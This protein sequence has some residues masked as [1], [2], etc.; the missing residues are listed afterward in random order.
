MC[1]IAGLIDPKGVMAAPALNSRAKVMTDAI[2]YRGPDGSGVWSDAQ[3]GVALGHRR[4]AIIDLTPTGAQP[5]ISADGRWVISYNGEVY[6]AEAVA[7]GSGITRTQRRGTSDT[8][9]IVES[10]ARRGLDRTVEDLNGMFAMA[11]WDRDTRTLHL[12]RD[13]LGI[14][15]LF[16]AETTTGLYFSSELKALGAAG[17]SFDIDPASVASF[18]RFGYVPA[19]YSIYRGVS[20]VLPGEIVSFQSTGNVRRRIYWSINEVAALGQNNRFVGSDQEAEARLHGLLADAVSGQM[21]SDVPLGA[22]LSGGIDSS[23]VV[24]LMVEAERGPVRT[25]SIGFPDFG[26]DESTHAR[27]VARHLATTHEELVVTADDALK[28]VPLLADMFDEPF[29]DSSQIPTY[30][31]AKMTRQHVKVA[32]TGDGGDELFGGYNRY[33]LASGPLQRLMGLPLPLRRGAAVA[34]SAVPDSVADVLA[35]V[36]PLKSRPAQPADKLKK[37]AEV[38]RLD[39]DAV[40]LRLVSQCPDPS[41]LASGIAEHPIDLRAQLGSDDFVERMQLFDARTYL[42][43]DI[44]QKVDRASMA[45]S[46]EVRPPIL[47]H[48]VVE[49]AWSLPRHLRIR[50]GETK[51]L[52]RRVLGRL[53]PSQLVDRPKMGFGVPLASWLRGPLRDWAEDLLDSKHLSGGPLD[54]RAVRE[55]WSDHIRG[56]RNWAY[57]LWTILMLEAWRRRWLPGS[58]MAEVQKTQAH[59]MVASE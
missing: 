29:A 25:F 51:W 24:A 26:Y 50:N 32:L 45:V 14:K 22:F 10:V 30:A 1:G 35:A 17:L 41:K 55:L 56:R 4:L 37:L 53:V 58:N 16:Y 21:I 13:R 5:M 40:Y 38:L 15:P 49:F 44:L 8:E 9:V 36:L 7:A 39:K 57:A 47:D 12:V 48:R 11:L 2:A 34:L 46:L 23:I 27:A 3:A 54:A 42:P 33:S 43:D 19:P 18:L 20:K 28:T 6:N 31:V 59:T 52:L